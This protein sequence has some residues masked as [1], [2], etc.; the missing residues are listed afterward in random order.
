MSSC[1]AVH[2]YVGTCPSCHAG[3]MRATTHNPSHDIGVDIIFCR[4]CGYL[5]GMTVE[6]PEPAGPQP[7]PTSVGDY[8]SYFNYFQGVRPETPP[9]DSLPPP[10]V[11]PAPPPPTPPSQAV[12]PPPPGSVVYKSGAAACLELEKERGNRLSRALGVCCTAL[13]Q[14]KE[15]A[16]A[17]GECP[18]CRAS[19]IAGEAVTAA[20]K[21]VAKKVP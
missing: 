1:G 12:P 19:R 11:Y 10:P 7:A 9:S 8:D 4:K 18:M 15:H 6:S 5:T 13:Y 20:Q 21:I 17:D 3:L 2:S 16:P 14:I